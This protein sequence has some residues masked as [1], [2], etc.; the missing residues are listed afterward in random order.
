MSLLC[1]DILGQVKD[2]ERVF[3]PQ[4]Y[5]VTGELIS[6]YLSSLGLPFRVVHSC[7]SSTVWKLKLY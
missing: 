4:Y 6:F 5:H 7:N 2:Q 1:G 3:S